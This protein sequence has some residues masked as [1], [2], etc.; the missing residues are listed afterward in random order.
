MYHYVSF[1]F[2]PFKALSL[3]NER[4]CAAATHPCV[5]P[6]SLHKLDRILRGGLLAGT[7]TEVQLIWYIMI[8]M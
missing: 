5:L 8:V 4:R 7:L 2:V 6:T 3:Y 1:Y